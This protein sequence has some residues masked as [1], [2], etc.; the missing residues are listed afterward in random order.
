MAAAEAVVAATDAT[1]A[2]ASATLTANDSTEIAELTADNL[3]E[4]TLPAPP[5]PLLAETRLLSVSWAACSTERFEA[6]TDTASDNVDMAAEAALAAALAV[7][8][9]LSALVAAALATLA[10]VCAT[11]AA[12]DAAEAA[13]LAVAA[14][15]SAEVAAA[16]ATLA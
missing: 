11:E 5:V 13:A 6:T 9:W 2:W 4:V 7:A 14:W 3:L 8:A 10:W 12:A 16:E 15:E 1:E